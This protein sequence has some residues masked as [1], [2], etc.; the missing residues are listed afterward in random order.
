[1]KLDVYYIEKQF[2][3]HMI[4]LFDKDGDTCFVEVLDEYD[5]DLRFP[6]E[7]LSVKE[8]ENCY[9]VSTKE[10]WDR[11]VR[12]NARNAIKDYECE[13]NRI[14]NVLRNLGE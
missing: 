9:K 11:W 2:E 8:I 14:K 5:D 3:D 4:H 1:M 10:Q 13:I 7:H 6:C 12:G